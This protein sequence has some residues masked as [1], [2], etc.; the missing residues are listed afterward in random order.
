MSERAV[1]LAIDARPRRE[2][3]PWAAARLEN[4]PILARLLDIAAEVDARPIAIHAREEE[5][6]RLRR[7]LDDRPR[8]SYRLVTGP[9]P[10]NALVL[11]VD[12]FYDAGRLR[13]VLRKGRDPE[14]AVL[15]PLDRPQALGDAEI[16]L[17]RRRTYQPL[18]RFWALGPAKALARLLRP[19]RIRPNALTAASAVC[20]SVASLI[21]G[22]GASS[23][24]ARFSAATAL[25]AGLVL[26]TADGRLARLQ[27]TASAFGRWLDAVLDEFGDVA[28]HAAVAWSLSRRDRSELWLVLGLVYLA[29]KHLFSVADRE[30][31]RLEAVPE[32]NRPD[33]APASSIPARFFRF[34]GHADFR[35]HLWIVLAA[36]GRLDLGLIAY[37]AYY[38]LRTLAGAIRKGASLA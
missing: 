7:L 19:T 1:P 15:W 9:T 25:S 35:W 12:R 6:D 4:R 36:L 8:E 31:S 16:E 5:H 10:E 37:A 14:S 24:L 20:V 28:L 30:W 11:R 2:D 13:R 3:G 33:L 29:G 32:P 26:D 38:P 18:G 21:A 34:L 17:E 23:P 22:S 27:G